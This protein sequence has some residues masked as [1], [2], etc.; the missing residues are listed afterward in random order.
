MISRTDTL[1]GTNRIS[2]TISVQGAPAETEVVGKSVINK[3]EGGT[4]LRIPFPCAT[5]EAGQPNAL[6]GGNVGV[7]QRIRKMGYGPKSVTH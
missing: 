7:K 1:S 3:E 4:V 6:L 2:R 5:Y